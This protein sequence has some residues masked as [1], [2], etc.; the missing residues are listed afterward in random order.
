ML[1]KKIRVIIFVIL[2]FIV[3]SALWWFFALPKSSELKQTTVFFTK[4]GNVA[5]Y[6]TDGFGEPEADF[7]WTV[8]K[9][10]SILLPKPEIPDNY[11]VSLSVDA[12]PFLVK[13]IKK[14]TISVF[15]ND[16]FVDKWVFDK[17]MKYNVLL[18]GDML[19]QS[20][21]INVKFQTENKKT[22]K[23]LKIS[24]D[25]RLLG[26]AVKKLVL[27][28]VDLDNPKGFY[29]YNIGDELELKINGNA[30]NY[31]GAGWS[32]FEKSFTWTDGQDAYINMFVKNAAGKKLQLNVYG[33]CIFD[34]ENAQSQKITV[35]A[36]G[37]E[38]T[39]WDCKREHSSY[40]AVLPE[41]VVGN[42]ALEI[43]FNIDKPFSPGA[44]TRKLGIAVK[45]I[46]ISNISLSQTKLKI[47][48][49]LKKILKVP[50]N[51]TTEETK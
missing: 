17:S 25:D 10:A 8:A 38:L 42:G 16:V 49:W 1:S 51:P 41:S 40:R 27:M 19:S 3:V 31:L 39:T 15:V 37:T 5:E 22:P 43:R 50:E 18:P 14:Q 32:G 12:M 21:M 26:I 34:P 33:H 11:G 2:V 9:E 44:D 46:E 35:Y 47:A 13:K 36:N 29:K 30:E 6:K 24:S 7:T 45:E 28:P 48:L 23:D 4:N 20:E